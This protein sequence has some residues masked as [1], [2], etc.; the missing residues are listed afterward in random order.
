MEFGDIE[1]VLPISVTNY[2]PYGDIE[3]AQSVTPGDYANF[4]FDVKLENKSRD[5]YFKNKE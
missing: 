3:K 2:W 4:E 5:A 1:A